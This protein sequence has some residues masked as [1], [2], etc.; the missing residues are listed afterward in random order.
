MEAAVAAVGVDEVDLQDPVAC[1]AG[2]VFSA[3]RIRGAGR[4]IGFD[5]VA[6]NVLVR[7]VTDQMSG[8]HTAEMPTGILAESDDVVEELFPGDVGMTKEVVPARLPDSWKIFAE[9]DF[10]R[11]R[12]EHERSAEVCFPFLEDGPEVEEHDVVVPD[13][14]VGRVAARGFQRVLSGADDAL[15]PMPGDTELLFRDIT[16]L[17]RQRPLRD[18]GSDEFTVEDFIEQFGGFVLGIEQFRDAGVFVHPSRVVTPGRASGG[19]DPQ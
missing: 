18:A 14:A 11:I 9:C 16:D 4:D 8:D 17:V 15:V 7:E 3:H 13:D 10:A 12:A 5:L 6:R 19:P 1:I 2:F